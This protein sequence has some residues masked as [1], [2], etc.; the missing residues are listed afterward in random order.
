MPLYPEDISAKAFAPKFARAIDDTNARG[1]DANL[2]CG[3]F[4][5]FELRID[6]ISGI[7]ENVGYRTN[8][9]GF[10]IAAAEEA[11]LAVDGRT[12]TGL[13]ALDEIADRSAGYPS[14]RFACRNAVVGAVRAAFA[15][16]RRRRIEE[17]AGE[18]ALICTC[19]GV[20]EEMIGR[21]R[22][23]TLEEVGELTNAGTG[24]GSCRMLI[25]DLIGSNGEIDML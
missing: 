6:D 9:C 20:T 8:G 23:S 3:A 17:F 4:V 25:E 18:K 1:A 22:A 21:C 10:M 14:D 2:A 16:L 19:F 15:D 7:I 12:L 11:A 13:R 5:R 24:C